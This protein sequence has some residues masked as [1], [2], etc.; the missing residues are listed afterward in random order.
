LWENGTDF[1]RK[2]FLEVKQD[3]FV[4]VDLPISVK[5]GEMFPVKA[6]V[7]NYLSDCI[8]V[9]VE[10]LYD[11]KYFKRI[12]NSVKADCMCSNEGDM[13]VFKF[14]L[15]AIHFNLENPLQV[16][17][18]VSA[19]NKWE[20]TFCNNTTF[21][22]AGMRSYNFSDEEM[23]P[24][25]VLPA[26][27]PIEVV[28]SD[29]IYLDETTET[30]AATNSANSFEVAF[31]L[32]DY[33]VIDNSDRVYIQISGDVVSSELENLE[34]LIV[35]PKGC[36]E[37][38][39]IAL[40]PL[41]AVLNYLIST[42]RLN[43]DLKRQAKKYL[44]AGYQ[45]QLNF[46]HEDGLYS[47]WGR[48]D[49][50]GGGTWL[51]AFVLNVFADIIRNDFI[52]ID[53][54]KM[55][56]TCEK[57]IEMMNSDGSFNH[58]GTPI[59]IWHPEMK[60]GMQDQDNLALTAYVVLTLA[61]FQNALQRSNG[62]N[63]SSGGGGGGGYVNFS[64][65]KSIAFLLNNVRK[66]S[67]EKLNTYALAL[68]YYALAS[69]NSKELSVIEQIEIEIEKRAMKSNFNTEVYW[70]ANTAACLRENN[71]DKLPKSIAANVELTSYVLLAKLKAKRNKY[72]VE[73]AKWLF[74]QKNSKGGGYSTQDTIVSIDALAEYGKLV[75]NKP[76]NVDFE[77]TLSN[78]EKKNSK[79]IILTE[80]NR[81]VQQKIKLSDYV[82][83]GRNELKFIGQGTGVVYVQVVLNFNQKTEENVDDDPVDDP[84]YSNYADDDSED[85]Q[86]QMIPN[87]FG[88]SVP[89]AALR[90]PPRSMQRNFEFSVST[91]V[92]LNDLSSARNK[93]TVTIYMKYT[94][95]TEQSAQAMVSVQLPSGF[96]V[97]FNSI[98]PLLNKNHLREVD[99]NG[100][101]VNFYYDHVSLHNLNLNLNLSNNCKLLLLFLSSSCLTY[102]I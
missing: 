22:K 15:E 27:N 56:K 33:N 89:S 46:I 86:Q 35:Q 87:V 55:L 42:D 30:N 52:S 81:N 58:K 59:S 82:K 14:Q 13:K 49:K 45:N 1:A 54:K 34:N 11:T 23:R 32:D 79:I 20:S 101:K 18:R 99:E 84:D 77:F 63:S 80:T 8:P 91:S 95:P 71:C 44:L 92:P 64:N 61:K 83:S 98:Q 75:A 65:L 10:L 25:E 50:A 100:D 69:V 76:M 2:E 48:K 74:V 88:L 68:T 21:D 97:L 53:K 9:K 72:I 3:F 66:N 85:K 39:M 37:Q 7:H 102:L 4:Y 43:D 24:I 31:N 94:G 73:I 28:F 38:N 41:V 62:I 70:E 93:R 19:S 47:V 26:G 57:L 40:A 17:A 6:V 96:T 5:K 16:G 60:G 51:S 12:P 78:N 36:G 90:R 67:P 29:V